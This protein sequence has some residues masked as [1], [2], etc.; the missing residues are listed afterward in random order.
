MWATAIVSIHLAA[1]LAAAAEINPQLLRLF[2]GYEHIVVIGTDL[3]L[4]RSSA[5]NR[6]FPVTADQNLRSQIHAVSGASFTIL[7]TLSPAGPSAPE[8]NVDADSTQPW[9]RQLDAFHRIECLPYCLS[10]AVNRYEKRDSPLGETAL[11]IQRLA[12]SY[13]NW[14]YALFPFARTAGHETRQMSPALEKMILSFVSASGGF[15][16]RNGLDEFTIDVRMRTSEDAAAFAALA[17]WLPGLLQLFDQSG[18]E[19]V[20]ELANLIEDYAVDTSGTRVTITFRL[21]ESKL[22]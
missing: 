16:F 6:R 13:D 10:E 9:F 8:T 19:P 15:R 17:H 22:R 4:H 12:A 21:D 18:S 1:T 2:D 14:F 3:E 20:R 7:T 11:E 5:L